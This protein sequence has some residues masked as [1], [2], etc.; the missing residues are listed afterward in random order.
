MSLTPTAST[1]PRPN[2]VLSFALARQPYMINHVLRNALKF[3]SAP[4]IVSFEGDTDPSGLNSP[5]NRAMWCGTY[6]KTELFLAQAHRDRVRINP[7]AGALFGPAWSSGSRSI[8]WPSVLAAT[9]ALC[10]AMSAS[11]PAYGRDG[12]RAPSPARIE[13]YW[14]SM[15]RY[16]ALQ[17]PHHLRTVLPCPSCRTTAPSFLSGCCTNFSARSRPCCQHSN[18]SGGPANAVGINQG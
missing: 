14:P 6:G 17:A 18:T 9:A 5:M 3:T 11:L 16:L 8:R 1:A 10:Q 15:A 12:P 4:M 2:V 13:A 7:Q